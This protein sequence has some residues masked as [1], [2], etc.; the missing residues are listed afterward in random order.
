VER[1]RRGTWIWY[2]A[3]PDRIEAMRDALTADRKP[4]PTR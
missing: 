1:E 2:R 4:R 3:V